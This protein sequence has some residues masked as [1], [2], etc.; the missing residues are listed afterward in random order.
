MGKR[1]TGEHALVTGAGGGIG[2]A[3]ALAMAREGAKVSLHYAHN[4]RGADETVAMIEEAGG[5]AFATKAD[6]AQKE[7]LVAL[8]TAAVKAYGEVTIL[9]N[10]A[11]IGS[12]NSPDRLLE[13]EDE[14]WHRAM[15]INVTA[16]AHL[17]QLVL[18]SM[19][20]KR[21][22]SII[23]ISSIRGM[24]GNPNLAVYSTSKGA[25]SMLTRQLACDYS[26]HNVRINAICPGFVYSE[27]F[28]SYLDKH[29]DP[30]EALET[31][32]SMAPLNRVG[33]PDEIAEVALFLA[34]QEASFITGVVFPV[35]GG[36]TA[37]GA[38]RVL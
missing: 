8:H 11:G 3:I 7:E 17:S 5:V 1:L 16:P 36:Y 2:R 21:R 26:P 31:F 20:E 27:M 6:L 35:D 9:V 15:A 22:G 28:A 24:L 19:I 30:Q 18:P 13:I 29:D 37:T 32:S 38:R 23:N 10:N 33:Q 12:L 4:S 25:L 34:S 14:D